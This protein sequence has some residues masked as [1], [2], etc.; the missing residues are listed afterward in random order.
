MIRGG[1]GEERRRQEAERRRTGG[2]LDLDRYFNLRRNDVALFAVK[3][4]ID[5]YE[6]A[7]NR[8]CL[9]KAGAENVGRKVLLENDCFMTSLRQ[10]KPF[11]KFT[12][13]PRLRHWE[14]QEE[15]REELEE[16][17]D[18]G[19]EVGEEELEQE[20]GVMEEAKVEKAEKEVEEEEERK[21]GQEGMEKGG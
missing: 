4:A 20:E 10:L 17:V 18:R 19:R 3:W 14:E 21:G 6:G 9:A 16:E 11:H 12:T 1:G 8:C 13:L 2:L 5:V 15:V 7:D